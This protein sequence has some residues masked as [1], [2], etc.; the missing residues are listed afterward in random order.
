MLG[1]KLNNSCKA[2]C[3]VSFIL[4]GKSVHQVERNIVKAGAPCRHIS[5]TSLSP[6]MPASK[7]L[8]QIVLNCL[9]TYGK[10]V[11]ALFSQHTKLIVVHGIGIALHSDFRIKTHVA[12]QLQNVKKLK[13]SLCAV[14][15][16]CSAAKIDAVHLVVSDRRRGFNKMIQKR[17]VID[18]HLLVCP[19][20]RIE[21]T[22]RAFR[23]TER[24]V[25]I[26]PETWL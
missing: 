25:N 16:R 20:Q 3:P 26:D 4:T 19:S 18:R 7:H 23:R 5:F 12:V 21:I 8:Q 10:P 9:D 17:L 22:V 24:N 13:Q 6:V 11:H 1:M 14:I 2:L 15:T